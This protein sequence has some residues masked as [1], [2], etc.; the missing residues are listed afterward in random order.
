MSFFYEAVRNL[1]SPASG[2]SSTATFSLPRG[3]KSI[4]LH[5]AATYFIPSFLCVAILADEAR[6]LV[7]SSWGYSDNSLLTW[8]VSWGTVGF[9]SHVPRAWLVG[10]RHKPEMVMA[11]ASQGPSLVTKQGEVWK[12]S[13]HSCEDGVRVELCTTSPGAHEDTQ[14]RAEWEGGLWGVNMRGRSLQSQGNKWGGRPWSW[15]Y[16]KGCQR[17]LPTTVK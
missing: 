3:T 1:P 13:L 9:L 8:A 14:L 5:N 12:W 17:V 2:L 16:L 4:F 11:C 10:H 15:D 7:P 6:L